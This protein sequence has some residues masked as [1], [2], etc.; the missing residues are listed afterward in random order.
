MAEND[1]WNAG[2]ITEFRANGGVVGGDFEGMA[3]LILHTTG[4]KSGTPSVQP[5]CYQAV[6]DSFAIFASRGGDPKHPGWYHNL[7]ADPT[8]SI[9]VDGDTIPVTARVTEGSER[10]GIWSRQKTDLPFFG[11]YE[12]KTTRTIP[13]VVLDRRG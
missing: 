8:A 13:V 9:E 2:V 12:K 1:D 7:V 3:L 6:G 4:A 5:L 11:D 10:E